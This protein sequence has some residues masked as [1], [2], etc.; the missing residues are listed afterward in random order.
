M[1]SMIIDKKCKEIQKK[2]RTCPF[3][4]NK[5]LFFL[6]SI[7]SDTIKQ[8]SIRCINC[9]YSLIQLYAYNNLIE[10]WNTRHRKSKK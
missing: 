8:Y 6:N 10:R 7:E 1:D 9:N 3:C 5:P 4:G 2:L